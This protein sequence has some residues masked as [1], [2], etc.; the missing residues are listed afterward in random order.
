MDNHR[1]LYPFSNCCFSMQCFYVNYSFNRAVHGSNCNL[2]TE[3]LTLTL[4]TI[5]AI[6]WKVVL[7][8]FES[9]RWVG[10]TFALL[11]RKW[12]CILSTVGNVTPSLLTIGIRDFCQIFPLFISKRNHFESERFRSGSGRESH[13]SDIWLN[14]VWGGVQWNFV[15]VNR[16]LLFHQLKTNQWINEWINEQKNERMT[17]VSCQILNNYII[18]VQLFN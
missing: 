11:W 2:G 17:H 4:N 7:V 5:S 16:T 6:I 10:R 14:F 3:S 1:R 8:Y 18:M 13:L 12:L 9:G 15:L